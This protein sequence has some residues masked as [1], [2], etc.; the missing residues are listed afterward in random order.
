MT[1][2]PPRGCPAR[3]G[4]GADIRV[5][6]FTLVVDDCQLGPDGRPTI[7]EIFG[8]FYA[9]GEDHDDVLLTADIQ[10][11]IGSPIAQLAHRVSADPSRAQK[12]GAA[13]RGN[14]T[15]CQCPAR[16]QCPAL[17]DIRVLEA[18]E[19]AILASGTRSPDVEPR[20]RVALAG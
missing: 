1:A 10:V 12:V 13:L 14:V 3:Y 7:T 15:G 18:L 2:R 17:T 9:P 8:Y 5:A 20:G 11:P 6:R 4:N 16:G 19:H